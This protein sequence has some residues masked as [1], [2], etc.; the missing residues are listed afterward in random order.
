MRQ[1][2]VLSEDAKEALH[3]CFECTDWDM[4]KAAATYN[5]HINIYEYAMSVSAHINKCMED[6]GARKSITTQANQISG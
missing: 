4:F 6:I 2:R 5:D 3:D 1:V